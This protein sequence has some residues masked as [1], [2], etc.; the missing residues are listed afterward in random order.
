MGFAATV[1]IGGKQLSATTQ[2]VIT[3]RTFD[4]SKLTS[5]QVQDIPL[6][7]A[8]DVTGAKQ[9]DLVVRVHTRT[10]TSGQIDVI[11]QAIS[12]TGE[13]PSEDF[14]YTTTS[15]VVSLGSV[16]LNVTPA[17]VLHLAQLTAPWGPMVRVI[18][19][20]T[21]AASATIQASIS[22]DLIVYDN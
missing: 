4:F 13:D 14:L 18:V 21:G 11:A 22:V 6:C 9:I 12:L 5:T 3:K 15:G 16:T 7:R 17:P 20:G 19:R 2:S 10:I 8:I 1:S